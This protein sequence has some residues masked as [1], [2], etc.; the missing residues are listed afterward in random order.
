M[1]IDPAQEGVL[2]VSI[3]S[4]QEYHDCLH[5]YCC[6]NVNFA[7]VST[8][9]SSLPDHE[10]L[11]PALCHIDFHLGHFVLQWRRTLLLSHP[12]SSSVLLHLS[13]VSVCLTLWPGI[14]TPQSSSQ[15]S[16][17]QLNCESNTTWCW[18]MV[19]FQITA[20]KIIQLKTWLRQ[21]KLQ[22]KKNLM[23]SYLAHQCK[24]FI[25]HLIQHVLISG[26]CGVW[27]ERRGDVVREGWDSIF[28]FEIGK[29][30]HV[31]THTSVIFFLS[32]LWFNLIITLLSV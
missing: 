18:G 21:S 22:E 23:V 13:S 27:K 4:S 5:A 8:V 9:H 1:T 24:D 14:R 29:T 17:S 20:L 19:V 3:M 12:I 6:S 10:G 15:T 32:N 16:T 2:I 25:F 11:L 30:K 31:K 28:Q 26:E 7:N